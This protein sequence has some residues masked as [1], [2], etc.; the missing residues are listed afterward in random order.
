MTEPSKAAAALNWAVAE[1]D[2][3]YKK[4][5]EEGVRE[6][7]SYNNTMR[8]K[9]EEEKVMAQVVIIIDELADLM[10]AAPSQVEESIC[11]L[12][13]KARAAG[14][15]LIVATQRPSVDVITGVIKANIP[16]RIAFAVSSQF[17]SR[18]ILD[19]SGAE[20]LVG[21]GDMLFN[22][23]GSGKPTRVQG[24]FISD[25][26]VHDVIEFV[27]GQVEKAE[28][29]SNVMDSIERANTPAAEKSERDLEDELLP[30][31]I[32]LVVQA[33]QASVSMLQRRFRI[34]YNRAAR[35]IDMM[36]DRQIVGPSDGSRPRQVLISEEDLMN[37]RDNTK[38]LE[39][40]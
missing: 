27:K 21:K 11:R 13:Q 22:P 33:Q 29:S 19:M 23:L 15:H 4:F 38:D 25:E 34:G 5:A 10:M 37:M 14:M 9:G 39:Q 1:M 20:K 16:S 24:T 40:E 35:I 28:Y 26:E 18:T 31:A 36:E 2:D 12:A 6:L 8:N 30:E 32:E 7:A 17:D 3:R